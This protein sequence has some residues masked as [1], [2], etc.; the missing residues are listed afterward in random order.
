YPSGLQVSY[1]RVAGRIVGVQVKTPGPLGSSQAFAT[2][3][4]Y[5]ALGQ[6][7]S[8]SWA[9]G[10]AASRSFDADGRMTASELASLRYDADGRIVGITQELFARQGRSGGPL[11]RLP[12]TW[13]AEYDSRD[14]LV[15]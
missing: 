12:I 6:P 14:R 4:Q 7:R 8:W 13:Q 3:I 9:S 5:T 10:D 1:Q 11:Y 2:D 15:S